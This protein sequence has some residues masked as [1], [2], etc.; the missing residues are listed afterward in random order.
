M[1]NFGVDVLKLASHVCIR[2]SSTL[3]LP[4]WYTSI[5]VS[6]HSTIF[7]A[8]SSLPNLDSNHISQRLFPSLSWWSKCLL[9]TWL[10]ADGVKRGDGRVY[11][12]KK[13]LGEERVILVSEE[14]RGTPADFVND[15]SSTSYNLKL[16]WAGKSHRDSFP[17]MASN[18][19]NIW[20]RLFF[21]KIL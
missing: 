21:F 13:V 3:F 12:R 14:M 4:L 18:I 11:S 15:L 2:F 20:A 19:F 7:S 9:S 8:E 16:R 6:Q 1:A 10:L 5:S 17:S